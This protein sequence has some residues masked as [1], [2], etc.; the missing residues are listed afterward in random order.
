[1]QNDYASGAEAPGS[2]VLGQSYDV[3]VVGADPAGLTIAT[4]LARFRRRVLVLDGGPSRASWIPESHNKPGFPHG[5]GGDARPPR[6]REQAHLAGAEIRTAFA[7]RLRW[8]RESKLELTRLST[9]AAD[10]RPLH[11]HSGARAL[12]LRRLAEGQVVRRAPRMGKSDAPQRSPAESLQSSP[13]GPRA[14]PNSR[15]ITATRHSSRGMVAPGEG[16]NLA[17]VP[18][19]RPVNA[20]FRTTSCRCLGINRPQDMDAAVES[21]DNP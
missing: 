9:V 7:G 3:I 17:R 2:S 10:Y 16:A 15:D 18:G 4:Y 8:G 5:I 14:S 6:L 12:G 21:V 11:L 1:M 19:C 20:V 13:K